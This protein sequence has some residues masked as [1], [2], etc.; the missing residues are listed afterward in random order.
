MVSHT[1][2]PVSG[3]RKYYIHMVQKLKNLKR[4]MMFKLHTCPSTLHVSLPSDNS[5]Y[6]FS[7]CFPIKNVL[8]MMY[9]ND[10]VTSNQCLRRHGWDKKNSHGLPSPVEE[11]GQHGHSLKGR[12]PQ[13]ASA[14]VSKGKH[15]NIALLG[16]YWLNLRRNTGCIWKAHQTLSGSNNQRDNIQRTL[17]ACFEWGSDS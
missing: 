15:P 9:T 3:I 16:F 11:R 2:K 4:D 1:G 12:A 8:N 10:A 6:H 7:V 14:T 5:N 17:R 13:S